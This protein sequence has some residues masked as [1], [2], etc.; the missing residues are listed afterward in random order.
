VLG[1]IVSL[2]LYRLH[3][4]A[5]EGDLSLMR[6]RIVGREGCAR[7]AREA[8]LP[9]AMAA[10]APRREREAAQA[11]AGRESVQAALCEA[12]IGAAWLEVG[13]QDAE[14]ATLEAFAP[15]IGEVAPGQRDPKTALQEAAARLHRPVR[16]EL[17]A[18][19]GPPH[20][21]TFETRVLVGGEVLGAG[22]GPSKQA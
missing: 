10:A 19:E 7:V 18:T 2:E 1:L 17:A 3:P 14:R 9:A 4:G 8:G 20:D 21:R 6:Q 15:L 13:P 16:Y 5:S 11:L 22:R 12:V